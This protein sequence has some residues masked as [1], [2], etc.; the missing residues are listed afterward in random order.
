VD[1][2]GGYGDGDGD[3]GGGIDDYADDGDDLLLLLLL[4]TF[5]TSSQELSSSQHS[6]VQLYDT[7]Q[8]LL[9]FAVHYT[10][11]CSFKITC[12]LFEIIPVVGSTNGII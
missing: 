12:H 6:T 4:F 8:V 2:T 11:R 3:G 5:L 1:G 7:Y 10:D 9:L